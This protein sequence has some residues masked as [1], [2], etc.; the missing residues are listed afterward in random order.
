MLLKGTGMFGSI[1]QLRPYIESMPFKVITDHASLQW[2][3]DLTDLKWP[4][5]ISDT[6]LWGGARRYGRLNVVPDTLYARLC[7]GNCSKRCKRTNR[8]PILIVN[9]VNKMRRRKLRSLVRRM[10]RRWENLYERRIMHT[11]RTNTAHD[12]SSTRSAN[13]SR[14]RWKN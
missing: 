6:W 14:K 7:W 10:Y 9:R 3:R 1:A 11:R 13:G 5:N 8:V 2:F 4:T 12:H